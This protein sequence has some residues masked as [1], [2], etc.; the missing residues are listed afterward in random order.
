MRALETGSPGAGGNLPPPDWASLRRE[1]PVLE[2]WIYLELANKAPLPRAAEQAIQDYIADCWQEGGTNAFSLER[3]E[4]AREA[5]ARLV[6]AP[7]AAIAFVRNTT[8]AINM[9]ARGLGLEAG[10][11]VLV[12]EDDYWSSVFGFRLLEAEGI[13]VRWVR[14]QEGARIPVDAFV[15]LVDERTRAAAIS[16]VS[17]ITGYRA[18][19]AALAQAC[20]ERGVVSVIDAIQ[21]VGVLDL[22]FEGCGADFIA[23]GGHKGMLAMPGC[24]YLYL[25][26]DAQDRIRPVFGGQ[27]AF[28]HSQ[29]KEAPLDPWP[30]A[31]RYEYGNFN[32]MGLGV[33]RCSA[34]FLGGIGLNHIEARVR[35]L[36]TLLIERVEARGIEVLTP[37]P[38]E[39]RAGI[40]ALGIEGDAEATVERLLDDRI[41]ANVRGPGAV[42]ASPHFY[43]TE[44]EVERF[45][46]AL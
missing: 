39:E 43:N 28:P 19:V 25:R 17:Y 6:D 10:D 46:A 42:R 27:N 5:V 15:E 7:P 14:K 18:D 38:W 35:E 13:E 41:R 40:V 23:C 33:L 29:G 31:R 22:S 9:V 30:D 26:E 1:F 11:N 32:Y 8:E 36:T 37:K 24:G 44:E 20:R 45:V 34:E 2:H 12:A 4:E 3:V 21:A 16:W